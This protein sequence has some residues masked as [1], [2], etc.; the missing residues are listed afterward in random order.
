MTLYIRR[1]DVLS[2]GGGLIG[3]LILPERAFA[4]T[5]GWARAD[6]IRRLV[7]LPAFPNRIFPITDFGA[8][9]DGFTKNT[10]AIAKAINACAAAGGGRVL[11]GQGRFLTGAIHLKSNVE[12]HVVEGATLLFSTDTAD[13]PIVHTRWEGVDLM[14]YSPLIYAYKQNNIAVTGRGLLDGQASSQHWWSWKGPGWR[15]SV[16][17]GWREGM[18]HQR[19]ARTALFQMA[20]DNVPVEKRIFAN[21]AFLRP[22]MIAP[23]GCEN[24]L[25]EGVT[26]RRAPF[27]LI[28][29][30]LC[31]N[32]TVRNVDLMSHGPNNDGCDPESTKRM[33]IEN[34]VFDTG[35]DCIAVDSGRN[36]EGRRIGVPSEDIVIRN[37]RMKEGHGALVIG[38]VISGGVKNVFAENCE[39]GSPNLSSAI[40]FKNNAMRGGLLDNFFYR[41]INVTEVKHA[42]IEC[43]FNYEEGAN[44]PYRPVLRNVNIA[45]LKVAK[46]PM[47]A[48]LQGLPVSP[49]RNFTLE[50]CA[51]D[52][53]T[54]PSVI[55]YVQGLTVRRLSVNGKAANNI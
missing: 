21:G 50:D 31:T 3:T 53:V 40:R 36:N 42:V 47:I 32:M 29:P 25:I 51:F 7:K 1:R 55:K 17:H 30:T 33:V 6:A 24:I 2:V 16:D 22:P 44:G 39:I 48:D 49:I 23:Y 12:L 15:G 19:T 14:G 8:K 35:D 43:D 13:Y 4:Q 45:N 28:H 54:T 20:E 11:V 27:W 26:M 52:G 37:C 5:A 41:N 10:A 38:S 46:A 9:G 18:P 34:C